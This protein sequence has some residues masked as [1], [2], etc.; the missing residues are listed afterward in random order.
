MASIDTASG[1]I[2]EGAPAAKPTVV[3]VHGAF[4]DSTSWAG[5]AK[6]L[7]AG[8]YPVVAVANPLRD[9]EGDAAYT[10]SVVA[11]I[12]GPVILA[13]HSYGGSVITQAA[14]GL[15]NVAALAYVA[16]FIPEVG[17]SAGELNAKFPGS[18]LTPDNLTIRSTADGK[19]DLYIR[20]DR[21]GEVYAGGLS[22]EGIAIAAAAQ[23]P[24]TA[25]ALGGVLSAAPTRPLP[26]LQIVTTADHAVPTELQRFLAERSGAVVARETSRSDDRSPIGRWHAWYHFAVLG[27]SAARARQAAGG[28]VSRKIA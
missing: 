5:V 10:A 19:T 7:A 27:A 28:F 6:E 21:F 16:A 12:D 17:E 8:G 25:E 13:G 9:L 24:V 22:P 3:L 11:T 1:S 20:A 23:R 2:G 15:D 26:R 18:L 4:A 14:A